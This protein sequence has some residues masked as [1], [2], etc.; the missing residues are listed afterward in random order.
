MSAAAEAPPEAGPE[1]AVFDGRCC[2]LGEGALW[3]PGR[4]TLYWFDITGRRLLARDPEGAAEWALPEMHS[5]AARIAGDDGALLV[6][7][8]TGL[9]RFDLGS[10]ARARLCPLGAGDPGTRSNDGRADPQGGF[11]IGTMG[12]AAEAGAGAIWRWHRGV[13]R[14][15]YAGLGIPNAIAFDP[16]GRAA[17][18]ADTPTRR[19][20][21]VGLDAEG[22]PAGE[23][24]VFL[25]LGPE[26]LNPDGAVTDAAGNLWVALWG[27]GRVAAWGPDGRPRGA[28]AVAAP[29]ASCP[30]FGGPGF[31]TLFVTTAHAGMDAAARAAH[32]QAGATFAAPGA[33][34]GRAEPAVQLA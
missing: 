1:A 24:S 33:G 21:R 5:A 29:Q 16:S 17:Y 28:V 22:W 9:W 18:F 27:A 32:P 4:Q 12:K 11:W 19:V 2:E 34:P 10:G 30:A 14:R 6:A 23:P 25:D 8:E 31:A 15:L 7:S 3:H 26:A 20:L 13:L